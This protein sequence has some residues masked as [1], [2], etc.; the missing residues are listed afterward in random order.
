[1]DI[2][3]FCRNGLGRI[4]AGKR[5]RWN[6]RGTSASSSDC[7]VDT[8]PCGLVSVGNVGLRHPHRAQLLLSALDGI[9]VSRF[10]NLAGVPIFLRIAFIVAMHA[11]GLALDQEWATAGAD[12]VD[13]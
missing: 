11:R 1:M 9:P 4:H 12:G 8:P 7:F 2:R 6:R 5:R 10:L 13:R 3:G